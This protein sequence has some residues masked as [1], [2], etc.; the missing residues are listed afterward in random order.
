MQI[1][2]NEES[3]RRL[4]ME[5]YKLSQSIKMYQLAVEHNVET[6]INAAYKRMQTRQLMF[7][8]LS[9]KIHGD[10]NPHNL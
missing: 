10:N 5:R 3:I 7:R 1:M 8:R 2:N 9:L 4:S 6:E